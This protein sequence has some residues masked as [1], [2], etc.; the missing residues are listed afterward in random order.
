[1]IVM[2]SSDQMKQYKNSAKFHSVDSSLKVQMFVDDV[3]PRMR[4]KFSKRKILVDK[5]R[6]CDTKKESK[7]KKFQFESKDETC[8][9]KSDILSKIEVLIE[10]IA[11]M[12]EEIKVM[13]S[14]SKATRAD[15]EQSFEKYD[16]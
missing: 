9:E 4:R 3:L 1:M 10:D 16:S 6:T 13:S 2:H 15:G 12:K 7:K 8:S 14:K 11:D 5:S